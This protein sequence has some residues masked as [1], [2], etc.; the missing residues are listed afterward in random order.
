MNTFWAH[1]GC[2]LTWTKSPPVRKKALHVVRMSRILLFVWC[3]LM[4]ID[5]NDSHWLHEDA[6]SNIYLTW[7]LPP[8]R[9]NAEA[10]FSAQSKPVLAVHLNYCSVHTDHHATINHTTEYKQW[11]G[12]IKAFHLVW[13]SNS[14]VFSFH[15]KYSRYDRRYVCPSSIISYSFPKK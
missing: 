8:C 13:T 11:S 5:A 15:G 3:N 9:R 12:S 10:W 1:G 14:R 2:E 7:T 4:Y 6:D